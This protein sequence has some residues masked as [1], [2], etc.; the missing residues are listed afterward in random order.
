M[1][2]LP[3]LLAAFLLSSV[4]PFVVGTTMSTVT[5]IFSQPHAKAQSEE[6]VAKI[7]QAI[8]VRVEGATQGSGVLV[9][10]DG[11]RYTILTAWHV[12]SD[13]K[14]GE[15]LDIYTSDGQRHQSEQ[16]S[17]KRLG[18]L[19][20]AE[21]K[22]SSHNTYSVPV[23][24]NETV[25]RAGA[26]VTI[27]GFP[28]GSKGGISISAGTLRVDS[29]SRLG[30]YG[31]DLI[32]SN[33]TKAG[34][35]GGPILNND[36]RLIGIHSMGAKEHADASNSP[37]QKFNSGTSIALYKNPNPGKPESSLDRMYILLQKA[38]LLEQSEGNEREIISLT[39][40][41][42][43]IRTSDGGFFLRGLA[44]QRLK[45]F[46]EA[47]LDYSRAIEINDNNFRYYMNRG[48]SL[49]ILGGERNWRAACIDFRKG[50]LLG[51]AH[52]SV[53]FLSE[54]CK[55]F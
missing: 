44:Y 3:T 55:D 48:M 46:E 20:L 9:K 49:L 37:K 24:S 16:G 27:S 5:L 1:R 45:R 42:L 21:I 22:F 29:D 23:V 17:I 14:P 38:R 33:S 26:P 4:Q 18:T 8:T 32:Y 6:V 2:R 15:E 54:Y 12:I 11:N 40:E 7:A 52:Q 43:A 50:R 13:Q 36:G 53:L 28:L 35:S 10:R 31:Y 19:D 47:I 25:F 41:A 39:T 30:F 51:E 34:M